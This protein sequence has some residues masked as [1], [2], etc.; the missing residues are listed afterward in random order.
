[1][2]RLLP[3]LLLFTAACGGDDRR[4]PPQPTGS[5]T[6]V[7]AGPDTK[8]GTLR[9]EG[10]E[11]PVTLRRVDDP[12]VPFTT[13]VPADEFEV[14]TGRDSSGAF[15]RFTAR[16]GGVHNPDAYVHFGFPEAATLYGLRADL[17]GPGGRLDRERWQD[18]AGAPPCLWAA[19]S[20]VFQSADAASTG[21]LCIGEHVG[22]P[23]YMLAHYPAEYGDGFGPR[24]NVLLDEFRWRGT[25]EPLGG[26]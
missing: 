15:S 24:L 13:F 18:Q 17:L 2:L 14:E 10:T 1:M 23:F 6:D 7:A 12:G 3:L 5:P 20:V 4:V 26:E 21:Q 19:E 22:R 11:Q 8:P 25:G 9:V 16:F